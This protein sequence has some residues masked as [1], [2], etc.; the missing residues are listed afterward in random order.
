MP[1]APQI[2]GVLL[3]ADSADEVQPGATGSHR[4]GDGPIHPNFRASRPAGIP[5]VDDLLCSEIYMLE[6]IHE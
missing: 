4:G 1:E 3:L 5:N 6:I 2:Y